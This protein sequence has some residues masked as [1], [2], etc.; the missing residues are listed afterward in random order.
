[1]TSLVLQSKQECGIIRI[2]H[3]NL[4]YSSEYRSQ[5][6]M[7]LLSTQVIFGH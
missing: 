4:Q 2:A 6:E 5:S 1:M 3:L 7:Q